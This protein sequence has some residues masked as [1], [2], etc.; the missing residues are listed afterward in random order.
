MTP[1]LDLA[2]PGLL[3]AF[4]LMT[5]VWLLSLPLRDASII[6]VFWGLG[7]VLL[8]WVYWSRGPQEAPRNLLVPVLVSLWG[9]RLSGYIL[10]RN[11][12]HGEDY[13]YQA[14]REK[15]GRSFPWLSL[16]IVFW[17]QAALLWLVAMP[18]LQAQRTPEPLGLTWLDALGLALFAVGLFFEAVGDWQMARF[19]ADPASKGQVMDRGLWRYTRHPNYFGDACAWWGLSLIALATPASAWVLVSPVVMTLLLLKVSGV[20]LLE[21]GLADSRP[22]YRDYV[23]RTSAFLPWPPRGG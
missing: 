2:L 3:T 21:K 14:M 11:W 23:R 19:K 4:G 6:D 1:I 18:L 7:F 10:W 22:G 16:V 8:A 12:G 13:R 5:L 17:L 15:Y 9:L 20:A